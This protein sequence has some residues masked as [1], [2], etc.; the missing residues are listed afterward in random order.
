MRR[1]RYRSGWLFPVLEKTRWGFSP[2]PGNRSALDDL[3]SKYQLHPSAVKT[4]T[5]CQWCPVHDG[6]KFLAVGSIPR[7][8]YRFGNGY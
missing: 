6:H 2:V 4:P 8:G 1:P 3:L 7:S 5:A